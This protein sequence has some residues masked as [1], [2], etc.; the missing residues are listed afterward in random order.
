MRGGV[1]VYIV[2]SLR[3]NVRDTVRCDVV[4]QGP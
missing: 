1:R 3:S 4:L 2:D